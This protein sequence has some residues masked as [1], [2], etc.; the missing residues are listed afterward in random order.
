VDQ[1]RLLTDTTYP[2]VLKLLIAKMG[3]SQEDIA[4]AEEELERERVKN[5][6]AL[7]PAR[8]LAAL[9]KR[10]RT[11]EASVA[12]YAARVESIQDEIDTAADR[13]HEAK[14]GLTAQKARTDA[15]QAD[16]DAT[17]KLIEPT[18][19]QEALRPGLVR[20]ARAP[21]QLDEHLECIHQHF[22]SKY[23]LSEDAA[24]RLE[25][26]LRGIESLEANL[27]RVA[28]VNAAEAAAQMEDVRQ[29]NKRE[30]SPDP[31]EMADVDLPKTPVA[32]SEPDEEDIAAAAR[33]LQEQEGTPG[34]V[35][36]HSARPA[37]PTVTIDRF[38]RAAS[39][40]AQSQLLDQFLDLSGRRRTVRRRLLPLLQPPPLYRERS[41]SVARAAKLRRLLQ[42]QSP[43]P[44]RRRNSPTPTQCR[45]W[46]RPWPRG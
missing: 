18:V 42:P 39:H 31:A 6:A 19:T 46:M 10:L 30:R 24:S 4:E 12:K 44:R 13:L 34:Q 28:A 21:L 1:K 7:P 9:R 38:S 5:E 35:V 29:S 32:R 37:P 45:N 20:P 41:A 2:S 17:E 16:I 36:E 40:L 15:I 11:S 26:Q 22:K 3:E 27:D 43:R 14:L 8:R 33:A 25:S 23:Q